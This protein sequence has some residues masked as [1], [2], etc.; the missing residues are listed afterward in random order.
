MRPEV[1]DAVARVL[2]SGW[3]VHGPE[4]TAF[5][6]ELAAY[7][8]VSHAAG[9][10]SGTDALVL[11]LL[12][13]GCGAGSEVVT[14]ANAGG[15]AST[16]AAQIAARIVYCDVDPESLVATRET[17]ERAIG[18]ETRAVV[19]THLYGNVANVAAIV[20][21][22]RP[23]GIAVIEDCA[24]AIGGVDAT[25]RRAGS[26]ADVAAFSFYPTKNLGAAGDGGAVASDDD[27][28][29][30][31]VRSLRQYGWAGKYRIA[32]P[33]GRNSRLDEI[34][35]AILRVGLV[36]LDQLNEE[37]RSIVRR[38][39]D[40][41]SDSSVRMVTG[42]G[43]QTVAHLA[44]VRTPDRDRLRAMMRV[45]E[46]GTDIHYPWPDH[47][48]A[49]LTPPSRVTNLAASERAA[50]EILTLPCFPGMTDAEIDRVVAAI[51]ACSGAT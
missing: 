8:G 26:L 19:V 38:Y 45:R 4:H 20:D 7:L 34:Q 25:G 13:V 33:G 39:R 24:Q 35:A 47:H 44:V 41:C 18:P 2:E 6:Q 9:V 22:C 12:A 3:Y 27:A 37:R 21:V 46:I 23:R 50:D 36:L 14:C 10:A 40:A 43:C 1:R 11:A 30:A 17:V 49:G 32:G 16:A 48:Q 31:R 42:A 5:E 15:Y 51:R 28:I 29:D